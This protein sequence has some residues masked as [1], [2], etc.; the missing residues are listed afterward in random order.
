MGAE[1]PTWS[2]TFARNS[3]PD[4]CHRGSDQRSR[5]IDLAVGRGPA[6]GAAQRSGGEIVRV[7]HR[8][9]D[10]RRQWRPAGACGPGRG[11]NSVHVEGREEHIAPDA[12]KRKRCKP[13][14]L[15]S[16]G[17][18]HDRVRDGFRH[19]RDQSL[20]QHRLAA[21][22]IDAEPFGKLGRRGE[23]DDA[24][25]V[26]SGAS[27]VALLA[28]TCVLG[29]ECHPVA[30]PERADALRPVNLVCGEREQVDVQHLGLERDPAERLHGVG[31]DQRP[32]IAPAHRLGDRRDILDG[33]GLVI[34]EH[35]GNQDGLG[36]D[37]RRDG[38]RVDAA[39]SIAAG[40]GVRGQAGFLEMPRGLEDRIV[41]DRTHH[42]V[43]AALRAPSL[44][45]PAHRE[46]VGLGARSGEDDL[47]LR[48]TEHRRDPVAGRVDRGARSAP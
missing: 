10:V 26:L 30:H 4:S 7:A 39:V 48:A 15:G 2:R 21:C 14:R 38:G 20:T 23:A 22:L 16:A 25:D 45:H 13:G 33:T 17:R 46:V 29:G 44:H 47:A 9:E 12:R 19:G 5:R 24:R 41:L 43:M 27:P 42:Q 32:R 1:A 31:V 28:T 11:F 6:G 37:G 35:D 8:P 34:D 40:D 36:G 18:G 3:W